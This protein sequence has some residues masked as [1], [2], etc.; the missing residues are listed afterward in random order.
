MFF[1]KKKTLI[2]IFILKGEDPEGSRVEY[3]LSGTDLLR[4]DPF[5]GSVSVIKEIDREKVPNN[6][7]RLVVTIQDEPE[8]SGQQPN[9]VKV[10]ISVIILDENDN[11]PEFQQE[12]Y[13]ATIAEDLPVGSTLYQALEVTDK[14]LVG[15]VLDVQC[16]HRPGFEEGICEGFEFRPRR[17]ETD[18]DMYRGAV[19]LRKPLDY[20]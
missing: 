9:I 6:E 14:D 11:E 7:V 12:P 1:S 19:V 5:T 16:V 8:E 17:T 2:C 18:H 15:D 4:A 3:G 10:P 13:K 20:R